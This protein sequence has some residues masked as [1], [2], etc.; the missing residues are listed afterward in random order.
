MNYS[1]SVGVVPVELSASSV[2]EV[3]VVAEEGAV[4]RLELGADGP[5]IVVSDSVD[6]DRQ[7]RAVAMLIP[8]VI[9]ALS[10]R[11]LN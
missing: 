9:R 3:P 10:A 7:N 4:T 11:V 8:E 1:R 5:R 2:V 6:F